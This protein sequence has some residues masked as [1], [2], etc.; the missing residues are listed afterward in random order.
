M[1]VTV[2]TNLDFLARAGGEGEHALG[3]RR[4][5][6]EALEDS[7]QPVVA[8]AI[9]EP[10]DVRSRQTPESV[11]AQPRVL[12]HD[13]PLHLHWTPLAE[14]FVGIWL[15]HVYDQYGQMMV[16]GGEVGTV[17]QCEDNIHQQQH[18]K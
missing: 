17:F 2:R 7:V 3:V 5:V 16:L 12:H 4:L 10:L 14:Y 18:L 11:E 13:R 1:T 9:E 15:G 8:G 6:L